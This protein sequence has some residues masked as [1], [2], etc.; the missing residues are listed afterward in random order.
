MFRNRSTSRGTVLRIVMVA[1]ML[2]TLGLAGS[3]P[4]SATTIAKL[5]HA[6][7]VAPGTF[8]GAPL[9]ITN[10]VGSADGKTATYDASGGDQWAGTLTGTTS[11]TGHGLIDLTTGE[12]WLTLHETFTGTV[13]G[14]GHGQLRF[15]DY[16]HGDPSG[17]FTRNTTSC[18]VVGGTGQ[19][20]GIRGG[21]EF[22]T[23]R[24]VDPDPFGNGTTYGDYS[25]FLY[26]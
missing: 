13:E 16:I 23:T 22:H 18:V 21:L 12:T 6:T 7:I 25:G 15:V 20:R 4:A 11:Y 14:F 3:V 24:L 10:A 5:P 19:L 2:A 17:D 9:T 1:A 26:R 8:V